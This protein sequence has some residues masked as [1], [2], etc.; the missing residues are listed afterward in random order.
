ML[1]NKNGAQRETRTLMPI[2]ALA[3]KA[4]V[5]TISPSG[6]NYRLISFV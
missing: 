3:P 5:S 1:T 4:S 6:L 2:K